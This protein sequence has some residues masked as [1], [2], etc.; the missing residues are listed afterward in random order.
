MPK[1]EQSHL[2]AQ[3]IFPDD[4]YTIGSRLEREPVSTLVLNDDL[5]G[6][7]ASLV[8][9]SDLGSPSSSPPADKLS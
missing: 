7:R 3:V 4:I 5:D 1:G 2:F 9:L 6:T 8:F